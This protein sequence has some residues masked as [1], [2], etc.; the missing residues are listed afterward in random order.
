MSLSYGPCPTQLLVS[1][2]LVTPHLITG[3]KGIAFRKA[4]QIRIKYSISDDNETYT[5]NEYNRKAYGAIPY[6]LCI[7]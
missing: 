7:C 6:I 2:I 3:P 4:H 5:S 1:T